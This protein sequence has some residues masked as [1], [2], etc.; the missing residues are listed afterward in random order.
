MNDNDGINSFQVSWKSA[1]LFNILAVTSA[2]MAIIMSYIGAFPFNLPDGIYRFLPGDILFDFVWLYVIGIL[3]GV[4]IYFTSP[5]L[6]ML[7]WNL[8][9]MIKRGGYEY[10]LQSMSHEYQGSSYRRLFLPSF[11]SLG[12][13]MSIASSSLANVI[14]VSE[15][16]D[17]LDPGNEPIF[18]TLP[19]LF[20]MLVVSST[21]LFLFAPI[22]LLE[23]SGAICEKKIDES[24]SNIDI[25]G[26]GNFYLKLLKG[27]A[28]VATIITYLLLGIQTLDWFNWLV[29]ESPPEGFPVFLY[30]LPVFVVFLSPIIALGPLSIVNTF[31]ELSAKKNIIKL[32]KSLKAN[33]IAPMKI[34]FE[35]QVD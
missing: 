11:V 2:A 30:S 5:F 1:V 8:H 27:F 21:I 33:G 20:I 23:D 9:R 6:A 25:E 19:I 28:G 32:E 16:F 24:R 3:C 14:F 12:L 4:I 26:V 35:R 18:I 10:H 7:F 15:S 13:A 29:T 17:L 31:Y 22:W 34:K